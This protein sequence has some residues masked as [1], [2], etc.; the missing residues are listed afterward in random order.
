MSGPSPKSGNASP[1]LSVSE[2][3]LTNWGGVDALFDRLEGAWDLVRTIEDQATMTG[4]AEF[5][6]HGPDALA[7]REE[8]RVRL[9]DGKAFDAHREYLFERA[10]HGFLV[11][12]AEEPPRLFHRIELMRA[13]DALAGSATHQCAPDV[14]DSNYR[15]LADGTFSIRHM[16]RGPRKGYVSVTMF[17][18]KALNQ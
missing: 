12:F 7:Y 15:F 3:L 6:R 18:R 16:V 9:A 5:R 17:T 13:G 8:G 11:C 14:Y 4:I 10:P 2:H 1:L